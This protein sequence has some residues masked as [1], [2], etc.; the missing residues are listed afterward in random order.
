MFGGPMKDFT[1]YASANQPFVI[2][3]A[4]RLLPTLSGA[5]AKDFGC[6]MPAPLATKGNSDAFTFFFQTTHPIRV[7][8]HHQLLIWYTWRHFWRALPKW[9]FWGA[10][11]TL[12]ASNRII[13]NISKQR[14]SAKRSVLADTTN[15]LNETVK[16]FQEGFTKAAEWIKQRIIKTWQVLF[17][18]QE[19]TEKNFFGLLV[20]LMS[21]QG[22]FSYWFSAE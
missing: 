3:A 1:L 17:K 4:V 20:C 5:D 15:R 7:S 19:I 6:F 13:T 16:H 2:V 8:L 10:L 9:S 21:G 14:V 11:E 12:I 22:L 18:N